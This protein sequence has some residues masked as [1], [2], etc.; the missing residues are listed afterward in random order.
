MLVTAQVTTNTKRKKCTKQNK[1]FFP[2]SFRNYHKKETNF[3]NRVYAK[4]TMELSN[5][6]KTSTFRQTTVI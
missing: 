2:K 6:K 5:Y 3:L 1:Y 4:T